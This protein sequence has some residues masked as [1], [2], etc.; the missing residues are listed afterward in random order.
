LNAS[1]PPQPRKK[2]DAV[3]L[4][5]PPLMHSVGAMLKL[6]RQQRMPNASEPPQPRKKNDVV[7]LLMMMMPDVDA[8][9]LATVWRRLAPPHAR[10]PHYAPPR[11]RASRP[12]APIHLCLQAAAAARIA[13]KPS[14][15][16]AAKS[17][18]IGLV[19]DHVTADPA[20]IHKRI[21]GYRNPPEHAHLKLHA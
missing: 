5:P 19:R 2:N 10:M 9:A 1:E 21:D 18:D 17:G 15:I 3:L 7:L 11:T 12:G 20:C 16:E 8:I 4:P 13:G 6:S 14:I